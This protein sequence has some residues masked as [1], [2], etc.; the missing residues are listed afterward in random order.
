MFFEL[1]DAK[2]HRIIW[3]LYQKVSFGTEAYEI[4][5]KVGTWTCPSESVP[6]SDSPMIGFLDFGMD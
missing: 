6:E 1:L 3:K 5:A 2:P 4:G